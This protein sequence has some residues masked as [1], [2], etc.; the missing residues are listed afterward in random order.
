MKD[1]PIKNEQCDT[2]NY[3]VINGIPYNV[4]LWSIPS[5]LQC[6]RECHWRGGWSAWSHHDLPNSDYLPELKFGFLFSWPSWSKI[7]LHFYLKI[8]KFQHSG[9]SLNDV[10]HFLTI[11]DNFWLP[12]SA[13][14]RI[15]YKGLSIILLLL[16]LSSQSPWFPP[17][18]T[19]TSLWTTPKSRPLLHFI[20][21]MIF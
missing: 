15:F 14:W 4:T 16:L 3:D 7:A 8:W 13:L 11:F 17:P 5:S 12:A 18:K 2:C 19:V 1:T 20:I 9:S 21:C 6:E 10:P